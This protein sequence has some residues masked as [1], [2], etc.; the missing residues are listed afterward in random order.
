MKL[1]IF[2]HTCEKY[3]ETR[4]KLLES[5]WANNTDIVFIT[6][7]EKSQLNNH[8]Y[9]GPYQG[10]PTYHPENVK[11]MFN[12]FLE[13]YNDYDFFMIVDDDSYVYLEKL[14]LYLSFFDKDQPYMI[15]DFLN[16]TYLLPEW[17]FRG[18]Y[19]NWVSGGPGIVFTKSCITEYIELYNKHDISYCNHDVW[20]H[21]LYKL[22]NSTIRRVHCP[23]FH[24]YGADRLYK[25]FSKDS[26]NLISVHFTHDM[27]LLEKYH[28][29]V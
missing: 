2:I 23:A 26:N 18:N 14:K 25:T 9:I 21:E 16:W 7:N 15:G 6:D 5:T 10:G 1:I 28:P 17:N 20:L 12:L 19:D 3:E 8:I 11:K 24:Q 22:S 27:S 29:E 4:S 13:R